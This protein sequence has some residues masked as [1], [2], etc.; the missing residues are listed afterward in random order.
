LKAVIG[1]KFCL[2]LA[3][4]VPQLAS[5]QAMPDAGAAVTFQFDRPALKLPPYTFEVHPDGRTSYKQ[6]N[7]SMSLQISSTLAE[8]I[9]RQ[10]KELSYFDL[11]CASKMKNIAD[12]GDKILSYKGPDGAG[13]CTYNYTQYETVQKLTD[14]F[15]AMALTLDEGKKLESA[16][17]YDRLSLYGEMTT[18]TDLVKDHRAVEM[19]L[20]AKTLRSLA[21]DPD[22]LEKVRSKA[23]TL[24]K[25]AESGS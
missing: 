2:A 19:G 18:L 15:Q 10:A 22:V 23:A 25:M 9:F 14:V 6:G 16:H 20:I 7:V 17:K 4:F 21:D 1:R 24:L 13:S 5:G 8:K 11:P 3:I 12:T